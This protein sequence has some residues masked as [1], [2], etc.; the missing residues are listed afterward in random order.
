[1]KA[2]IR[3]IA[4]YLPELELSNEQLAA[5]FPD[6]SIEK[7]REK[8]GISNR[9]IVGPNECAS[10][11][12]VAACRKLFASGVCRPG[13][14][15]FLLFCTQSPDHFLPTTAC[16]M[17]ERLGLPT[18]AGAL[19]FNLGCSGFIYGLGLA[20]GLV[21]TGQARNVLLV[22]ADTYSKHIHPGDRSVRTLFGDAAAATLISA[23]N[24]KGIGP[25]VYGTDGSGGANLIVPSGGMRQPRTPETAIVQADD[26]GN[27]RSSDNIFM[28]G[29]E[30]FT[31]TLKAVPP[32]VAATLEK[33]GTTMEGIDFF[34]FHQANMYMLESLRRKIHIPKEKFLNSFDEC[35]NTVSST[36]PIV[37]QDKVEEGVIRP[38]KRL[39]LVGFG[40]G[41]SWGATVVEWA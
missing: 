21:E 32:L 10:D 25:F 36:I 8:T 14:I 11:L 13:E 17:Q 22:T 38:G 33:A 20:K 1:M 19:D 40:V 41:Y 31:F 6:W 35:G 29:P 23:G 5:D 7:I 15:D 27:T 26:Q 9:H 24:G 39:L 2:E 4:Y 30:I 18:A 28:D 34:V 3:G 16:L 12:G 37:L